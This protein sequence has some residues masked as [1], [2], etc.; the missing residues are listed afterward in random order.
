MLRIAVGV[1]VSITGSGV[2]WA[3]DTPLYQA[4]PGWVKQAPAPDPANLPA[5]RPQFLISDQQ[6]RIENGAVAS[7]VRNAVII[8]NPAML[9]EAGTINLDWQ[10]DN[11]DVIVHHVRILRGKETIDVLAKGER[12]DV[13][14]RELG[15]EQRMLTGILTATM[16]IQGMRVGDVLDFAYTVTNK[17]PVLKGMVSTGMA[18]MAKPATAAL[19]RNRLSWV[20]GEKV[21]LRSQVDGVTLTPKPIGGFNEV[22]V[23]GPIAKPAEMPTDAPLRF[24]TMPMIEASSFPDWQTVSST[25]APLYATDGLIVA[26]SALASEV[27]R[28]RKT[29]K[30]PRERAALALQSVQS[31]VRYLF[32]GMAGGNYTPQTPTV[33]WEARYGDC[34]AKTL[35]LLAMLHA[36]E[37]DAEPILASIDGGDAVPKRLPGA[38]AFDHVLVH[39]TIDGR[40]LWLD[41]TG[42]GARLAD[43]DDTPPFRHVLPL[44]AAG[45]DL[46][47][48][49]IRANVRPDAALAVEMDQSAGLFLPAPFRL[50][51]TMRGQAAE[52]MRLASTQGT[53]ED[54]EMV[55]IQIVAQYLPNSRVVTHALSFDEAAN[56]GTLDVEG[57]TQS[58]WALQDG[59]WRRSID[60]A[61]SQIN[62][63]PDRTR[64]QWKAIPVATPGPYSLAVTRRLILPDGGA[65]YTIEGDKTL[66]GRLGGVS[67]K[68]TLEMNKGVVTIADRLD[69]TAIE[70]APGDIATE[71]TA[72]AAAERRMAR[73]VAPADLPRAHEIFAQARREGKLKRI[74]ALY[75]KVVAD[76]EPDEAEAFS[77][78]A[79]F[80]AGLGDYAGALADT[81]RAIAIDASSDNLQY[82]AYLL[83]VLRRDAESLEASE[84]AYAADPSNFSGL[85]Y[86]TNRLADALR[87][88]EALA[89]IEA[90]IGEGG[91]ER[92]G[93]LQQKASLLAMM[94]ESE[95]AI[96]AADEAVA[97][98]PRDA[99]MLSQ[100][101]WL[102]GVLDVNLD[103]ALADC[104]RSIAVGENSGRALFN[105]ALVH[106][107]ASRFDAARTDLD[108]ALSPRPD[109]QGALY[110]RGVVRRRK[111][112]TKGGD[113]DLAAARAIAPRIADDYDRWGIKP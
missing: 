43:L 49:P 42:A 24:Q 26:G 46:M 7:Y 78:R 30:I 73:V 63:R 89:L 45:A 12:F 93:A 69:A 35:L 95:A 112:D 3:G 25:F 81:D 58:G 29:A 38:A 14:K 28:I 13:L 21:A 33:T 87:S 84:R 9:G 64:S 34:K 91:D 104:D 100:R 98:K 60:F 10:P 54:R 44:R 23:I 4:T 94:G 82:R 105:R 20:Q 107:R 17:D 8:A 37:I 53:E 6:Q 83:Y 106:L 92:A 55:A 102:R 22:E 72:L 65:G 103:A 50:T 5:V 16:Q 68:R 1:M 32:R 74:E 71:R 85:S 108:E 75:D 80:R 76:A 96:A 40:S 59:R 61:V 27:A 18:V 57:F 52:M 109:W 51:M 39:A 101:C 56:T 79:R 111:G 15:L 99:A 67:V 113:A 47:A 19:A 77:G 110:L 11:G 88:D 97:E 36:L 90:R 66:P 31:E 70:I 86:Y 41:G 48:L 2:A 62:F